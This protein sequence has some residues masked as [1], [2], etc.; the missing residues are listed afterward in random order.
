MFSFGCFTT[1]L[2]KSW[3]FLAFCSISRIWGRTVWILTKP[4]SP[5]KAPASAKDYIQ[6]KTPGHQA[7]VRP[8][9]QALRR[10]LRTSCFL[11]AEYPKENISPPGVPKESAYNY[12]SPALHPNR[13]P[14][15][16]TQICNITNQSPIILY[17]IQES[18]QIH[19]A[20][21]Q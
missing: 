7:P 11:E 3:K 17:F 19:C 6:P 9:P 12:H 10:K 16:S 14:A 20:H 2:E 5:Q 15:S 8:Q 4:R 13:N 21:A 18:T 1:A